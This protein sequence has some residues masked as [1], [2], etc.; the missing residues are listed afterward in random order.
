MWCSS[1]S[2]F[3]YLG[4]LLLLSMTIAV[5]K[6]VDDFQE[7]LLSFYMQPFYLLVVFLYM[8][9]RRSANERFITI[10]IFNMYFLVVSTIK[11]SVIMIFDDFPEEIDGEF[12]I[13]VY[14]LIQF[15]S[16]SVIFALIVL[17]WKQ[18]RSG[19][20]QSILNPGVQFDA[21]ES[22]DDIPVIIYQAFTDLKSKNCAICLMDYEQDDSIK[23]LPI[24]FH[25]FHSEWIRLW[26]SDN[27]TCPF[28]RRVFT[29]E[30]IANSKDMSEDQIYR[31][32]QASSVRP[33]LFFPNPELQ[34]YQRDSREIPY[35]PEN[36]PSIQH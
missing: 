34:H 31:W 11:E 22:F 33:S 36:P 35:D 10:L 8:W 26:F 23:V 25:T 16:I 5:I 27:S 19:Q 20:R 29:Q 1:W 15:A 12:L 21:R 32:I 13:L 17:I 9:F 2:L 24:W 7:I 18:G 14:V 28:W 4:V 3:V 30:D 6:D